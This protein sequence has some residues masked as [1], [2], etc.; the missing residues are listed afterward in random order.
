MAIFPPLPLRQNG[1][2]CADHA[3]CCWCVSPAGRMRRV[4]SRQDGRPGGLFALQGGRSGGMSVSRLRPGN[5]RGRGEPA[6]GGLFR[7]RSRPWRLFVQGRA[8]P[9]RFGIHAGLPW[10]PN[11]GQPSKNFCSRPRFIR[12][13]FQIYG[14]LEIFPS[15]VQSSCK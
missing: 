14:I 1:L 12:S 13:I 2:F 3:V 4:S 5:R 6:R 8:R 7:R 11:V 9:R 15:I 10:P